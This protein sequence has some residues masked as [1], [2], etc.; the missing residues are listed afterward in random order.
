MKIEVYALKDIEGREEPESKLQ[1]TYTLP[2]LDEIG[3]NEVA[4]K[5]GSTKPKVTLNFELTRSH[6]FKLK[7][8][9]ATIDEK[10]IEEVV[11][12]KKKPEAETEEKKEDSE[13]E[14]KKEEDENEATAE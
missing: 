13:S 1:V 14:E 11:V 3:K 8:A 7:S 9:S 10:I 4:L 6:L 2:S 12:E 5:E